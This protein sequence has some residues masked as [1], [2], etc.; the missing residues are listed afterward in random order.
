MNVGGGVYLLKQ[1][2]SGVMIGGRF[3]VNGFDTQH[4]P[5]SQGRVHI[6]RDTQMGETR[7]QLTLFRRPSFSEP[8]PSVQQQQQQQQH[9]DSQPAGEPSFL[10]PVS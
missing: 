9:A 4:N 5:G 8:P 3:D 1:E 7:T 6:K 10:L 2:K